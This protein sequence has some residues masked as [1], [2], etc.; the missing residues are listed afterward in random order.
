MKAP[1]DSSTYALVFVQ[2]LLMTSVSFPAKSALCGGFGSPNKIR[3]MW[4]ICLTQQ[5]PPYVA[6]LPHL[7]LAYAGFA[8]SFS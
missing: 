5:N 2:P 4:R 6:D 7:D 8:K 3:L 1:G